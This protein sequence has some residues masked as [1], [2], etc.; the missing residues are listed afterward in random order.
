MK[1]KTH[2]IAV[3][4]FVLLLIAGINGNA[5]AQDLYVFSGAG[6]RQPVDRVVKD[7]QQRTGHHIFVD[8]AGSGQHTV[9]IHMASKGDV[10][11]PGSLFYIEKLQ[12]EGKIKSFR[13]VAYHTPVIGVNTGQAGR[14]TCFEDLA[15]PGIRLAMGDPKAMALGRTAVSI[16]EKSGFKEPILKNVT[17]YGATVKQLALYVS[18]GVVD[19]A[20]IGRADAVQNAEKI[21]MVSIPRA[22]FEPEVIA[23]AVLQSASAPDVAQE[24]C[25]YLGSDSGVRVFQEY[26]FLPIEE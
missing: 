21:T 8:Y 14:I 3:G 9:K 15:A 2:G 23:A 25:D 19:A 22:W 10:F 1:E 13:P 24:F 11:I 6:L 4:I 5:I 26:G 16:C 17:V 12:A 18:Q 7:F 20:I